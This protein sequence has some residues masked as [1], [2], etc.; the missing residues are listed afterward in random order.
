MQRPEGNPHL[1]DP[2]KAAEL[3]T[4]YV[5]KMK[6]KREHPEGHHHR[7]VPKDTVKADTW[8]AE[9]SAHDHALAKLRGGQGVQQRE[10]AK[11]DPIPDRMMDSI[12]KLLANVKA[13]DM[14]KA[15]DEGMRD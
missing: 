15:L 3:H 4:F 8:K 9:K 12:Q 14:T 11:A 5:K 6:E 2:A 1:Y 13:E 10:E 7:N